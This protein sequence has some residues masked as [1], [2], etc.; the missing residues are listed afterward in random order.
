MSIGYDFKPDS[1]AI[2]YL[3]PEDENFKDQKLVPGSLVERTIIDPN[4][5]FLATPEKGLPQTYTCSGPTEAYAGVVYYPWMKV[6]YARD[7]RIFFSSTKIS[8]PSSKLDNEQGS[9]FCSDTLTGAVSD[10]LP[11]IALD[12]T[13]DNYH[14]FDFIIRLSQNSFPW[15]EK[16]SR[17]LC[18][19]A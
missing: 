2:A 12:F 8:L 5:K 3:K 4:G 17:D 13:Q 18:T 7:S 19:W 15:E 16:Y 6:A 9:V 14:L 1:Q 11:Q 10:I